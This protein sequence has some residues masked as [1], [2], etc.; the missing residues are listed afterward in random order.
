MC[1]LFCFGFFLIPTKHQNRAFLS[2]KMKVCDGIGGHKTLLACCYKT[3]LE[4]SKTS[5]V[6]YPHQLM[7]KRDQGS[8]VNLIAKVLHSTLHL[9]L[10]RSMLKQVT[11]LES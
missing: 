1:Y 5:A 8:R 9:F 4:E 10:H 7:Q 2:M 3:M 11:A 6:F